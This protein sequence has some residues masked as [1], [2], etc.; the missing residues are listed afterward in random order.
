[1]AGSGF[2][3]IGAT[4]A[5][6]HTEDPDAI[7]PTTSR[8]CWNAGAGR[9]FAIRNRVEEGGTHAQMTR[10]EQGRHSKNAVHA[11]QFVANRRPSAPTKRKSDAAILFTMCLGVFLAQLDSTVVYLGVKNIGRD[12]DVG[13]SQMQWVLDSYN[14][15]YATFLLTGGTLGDLYGR[16]RIYLVG[17]GLIVVGSLVCTLAPNGAVLIAAR[18]VTGLGAALEVPTSLAIL[19]VTYPDA[20]ERGRAIGIWASCNGLAIATGPTVG[21]LL[22]DVAGWRSIFFLSVPVGLLAIAMTKQ[23]VPES[24]DPEGRRLDPVG[25]TLAI[26][27]LASLAFVTI[28]GPHWGWTTPPVIALGAV[29]IA[30]AIWFLLVERGKPDALLPLGLFGNSPFNAALAIAGMMTFGMYAMMF[31]MPLYL[32]SVRGYSAFLAGLFLVPMSLAFVIVSQF[33]GGLT[34]R[35]GARL[36]MV[37][38]MGLMGTGLLL[39][40]AISANTSIWAIEAVLIV[41]GVGLGL[42]TGPVNAVAV[43]SVAAGRFG[44][45]SGLLN[46]TRMVGA[47]LGIAVLG[48][49]FAVHAGTGTTEGIISGLRLAYLGGGVVELAGALLAFVFI[50]ADSAEQTAR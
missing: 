49:V 1:M 44:T 9:E 42:N 48:A 24:R 40:A 47:T 7:V 45:A 23:C 29:S 30:A 4:G 19:A 8:Q 15:A 33:S 28:E 22:V 39:L 43:A 36:M 18:A 37:G 17:I 16:A 21:G 38:G 14:L 11:F 12:L 27:A 31:L 32:Q 25:Q 20:A 6:S 35:V 26:L 41:I 13:I 34:K 2:D 5:C 46:T 10:M 50:R 3:D